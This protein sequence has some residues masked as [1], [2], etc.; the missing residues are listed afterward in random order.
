M[1]TTDVPEFVDAYDKINKYFSEIGILLK[2]SSSPLSRAYAEA[3]KRFKFPE[4]GGI[5]LGF[6]ESERGAGFGAKLRK[7]IIQ[8]AYEIIHSGSE[9]PEIF[10]LIGLFEEN[11]GPD[12]LSDMFARIVFDNI[13]AYSQRIY[14]ELNIS[15]ETYP[16]YEFKNGILMNPY[17]NT[18]LLLLPIDILHELPIAHCW[19]DI[20]R[21]C[22]ENA[23]IRN[24]INAL[25][26]DRWAKMA[27][28]ERKD[29]MLNWIFKNPQRVG[30]I[31]ESYK[32]SKMEPCNLMTNI[33]YAIGYILDTYIVPSI[34][35]TS[36][37]N[38]SI[39]IIENYKEW[40]ECHRGWRVIQDASSR[41]REK[42]VQRT[43]HGV[44]MMCC[45]TNNLDIS[46]ETDSGRG[47]EDFKISRGND[48]KT[49]IEIKLTSNVACVHGYEVQIEEHAK[50][51]NTNNKI[52]VLVNVGTGEKRISD[53]LTKQKEMIA[54]GKSP[55]TIIVIDA[56]DKKSA[57][58]L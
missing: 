38:M 18:E 31:I 6:S 47:P 49:V 33:D 16:E 37:Y 27:T 45:K 20:D 57:S 26:G 52:F 12:R 29:Y 9:Q 1:Q 30:R 53:V 7:K 44:A 50:A 23:L 3:L 21:V 2:A 17:K 54:E 51:E 46:P 28:V 35:S 25:V 19:D 41:S 48:D 8:D 22:R 32:Q 15:K 42:A 11:V 14:K 58:I 55:S 40:V 4:V 36:S 5:N 39:E 24:E 34:E 43:L 56:K 13:V 10:H